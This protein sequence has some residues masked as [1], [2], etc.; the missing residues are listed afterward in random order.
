MSKRRVARVAIFLAAILA[1]TAPPAFASSN[2]YEASRHVDAVLGGL[3]EGLLSSIVPSTEDGDSIA[4]TAFVDVPRKPSGGV[5]LRSS[6]GRVLTIGLPNVAHL[7]DGVRLTNGAVLYR[8]RN[9]ADEMVLPTTSGAQFLTIIN[10]KDAP[11]DYVYP[12]VMPQGGR[13]ELS[14]DGGAVILD[15]TS[16]PVGLVAPA[17]AFDANHQKVTTNFV[18]NGSV[19][20]QHIAHKHADTSYPVVA[21]PSVSWQAINFTVWYNKQEVKDMWAAGSWATTGMVIAYACG[22]VK[23]AAFGGACTTAFGIASWWI[24]QTFADAANNNQCVWIT[25][26]YGADLDGW[27]RYNC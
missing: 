5:R 9:G 25:I 17:W 1:L 8:G 13:V 21:D 27:G 3:D 24:N 2:R 10:D 19:L 20:T 6:D 23:S 7:N 15:S 12:A 26:S 4:Q 22:R 16:T 14:S 18:T 11:Q